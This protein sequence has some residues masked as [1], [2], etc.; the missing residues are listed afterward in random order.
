[1]LSAS[2]PSDVRERHVA[3]RRLSRLALGGLVASAGVLLS[4][5]AAFA[6]DDPPTV[7]SVDVAVKAAVTSNNL[8]WV[9]IGAAL[10]IF[11]QAG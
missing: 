7:E 2:A 6:A 1:M 11:M 3:R 10:V 5:G 9:V 4:A 8:L